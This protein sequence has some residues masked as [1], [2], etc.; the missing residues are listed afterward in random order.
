MA[1]VRLADL[2]KHKKP[3]LV[4]Q[5]KAVEILDARLMAAFP[6]LMDTDE[7]WYKVW[8]QASKQAVNKGLV[9]NV[10]Y[11][12][13]RDNKSGQG[14]R[15]CFSSSA[16]MVA[17]F[18]GKVSGDDE[19]NSVRARF[20][21]S[22][23]ASAQ[24]KALHHFGLH[25][26][27]RQNLGLFTLEK[28]TAEGRPVLVGWLHHGSYQAP[29]GGGHWSVVVGTDATSVIHNDPYGM[30]DMVNGSYKSAQGGKYIHYSKQYWLP[31][32]QVEG[33]N[34]GWGVLISE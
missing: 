3:G 9:L 23:D 1:R 5:D 29:S 8:S 21:D 2:F 26:E 17:K 7:E 34:S 19:Y 30:A 24:L 31:R 13:Q 22:T 33:A 15:E 16:A 14:F 10:P 20:G 11:E 27:F 18:Y 28:E 6:D 4:Y 12:S 32:W 25:A